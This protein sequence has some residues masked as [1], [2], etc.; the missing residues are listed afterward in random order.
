MNRQLTPEEIKQLESQGCSAEDW[1]KVLIEEKFDINRIH[2][3]HFEGKVEMR[4]D[5]SIS[6]VGLIKNIFIEGKVEIYRVN[7]ITCDKWID[8]NLARDG[9]TVGNE[10]G[11]PNIHFTL[12]PNEQLD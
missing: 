8:T 4:G 6:H 2:H 3:T 10:A 1:T 12:S 7:E 9:I 11:E 5:V